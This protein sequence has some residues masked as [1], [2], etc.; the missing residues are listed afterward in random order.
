MP[1]LLSALHSKALRV[2]RLVCGGIGCI[3]LSALAET[4]VFTYRAPETDKDVRYAYDFSVLQLA[5]EKTVAKYG[6]YQLLPSPA[7]TFPRAIKMVENNQYPNFFIKLSYEQR[8]VSDLNFVFAKYPVDRGIVGYRVCFAN[9]QSKQRLMSLSSAADLRNFVMGQGSGWADVE[10]LRSNGF[11][12]VEVNQ[13][14]NLFHMVAGNRFD[15][16]C[17]GANELQDEYEANKS[18]P[19]L[20]YDESMSIAY[21]LPRFFFGHASNRKA[22]ERIEEGLIAAHNDGSLI[23]M[24]RRHYASS[25]DFVKLSRRNI[26]WFE[27]PLLAGLQFNYRQYFFDPLREKK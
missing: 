6:P 12:V 23:E 10:I 22:A 14:E 16:F 24:W 20:V 13:Y 7:M 2:L 1:H 9:P 26:Y 11:K 27:N 4:T 5:L 18:I 15:L 19:N 8:L 17:R 25:I 21:P 3:G